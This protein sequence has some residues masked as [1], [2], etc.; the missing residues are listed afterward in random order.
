MSIEE[1][2]KTQGV[3]QEAQQQIK[4]LNDIL[5]SYFKNNSFSDDII[6]Y[7]S[8]MIYTDRPE[9]ENELKQLLSDFLSEKQINPEDKISQ[10]CKDIN[11]K[12]S[13]FNFKGDRK[14]IVAERLQNPIRLDNVKVGS[15]N[16]IVSLNFDPNAL[17]FDMD[18]MYGKGMTGQIE[19]RKEYVPDKEKV[20]AMN[21][22]MK[23]MEKQ[24]EL[25]EEVTINHD[26]D[27]SHKCDI[28]I[29][30]FTMHIGGKTLIDE[31]NLKIA[32]GRRYVLIGRNGVGKTTLLNHLMRKEL[33]G[34]PKSLQIVHVEQETLMTENGLLDEILLC[35]KERLR[36]LKESEDVNHELTIE[37]N[38]KKI[39]EL[40]QR[41]VEINQRLEEIGSGEAEN[42]AKFVLLG[43]GFQEKDFQKKTKDFSGGWRVRISLAKALYVMPDLLLLDEPTNHLD[44]NAVMWLEDYLNNWP[45][46]LIIVSHARDFI[47]N[48]ATDIIHFTNQKLY[49]YKG[50]Y[51]DFEKARL[52]RKKLL[53]RQH[54]AQTQKI[55]H[56]KEFIDKFRYNAKRANLV[57]SRIKQ[58][59]KIEV[60]EEILE[61]PTCIFV[62]PS[63]DKLNPPILRLDNV[64]LGYNGNVIVE[65]INLSV[66]MSSRFALVGANGCGKTTVLKGLQGFLT[67]MAGLCY[68]HAKL[69]LAV[70]AQHHIDQLDLELSPVEQIEKMYP[71]MPLDKIRGHLSSF[72][73]SGNLALRP[74]Y[75]LSGGQK[76]RV[77]LAS[78]VI[79]NPEI[80]LMDEPTNHLDIDAVNAL[81]IA[82]N[83]YTGG[84]LIVSHDQHFVEMVCN[85]IYMI[86]NKHLKE[87]RGTFSDYR[88][89]L[90][91]KSEKVKVFK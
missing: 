65:K 11:S 62:F 58:M 24:R 82:L 69:K 26:R 5:S 76:S 7:I 47:N 45:Y 55:E 50:N 34:V 61:D 81:A 42:K 8:N 90:R 57:Q 85:K 72:G 53:H 44:M 80:I 63:T 27:E 60:V 14:A 18:R 10:I 17:T 86:E 77:A 2:S 12:L 52:E 78:I 16:T 15:N 39:K 67:P 68:R 31:G 74:N 33:D 91:S 79:N 59:N 70:F 30:S 54:E 41:L 37:K 84:L 49:Y 87:F 21:D 19:K 38:E 25:I 64:D 6:N 46:T 9:N 83:S 73:I 29:P 13:V 4:K 75:L 66:D 51:E 71:D 35:D 56:M 1:P 22:F 32:Y 36:L 3:Q 23:E 48:V 40:S 89:Y 28:M 88:K 20:K 43:L